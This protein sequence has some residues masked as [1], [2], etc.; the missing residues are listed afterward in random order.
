MGMIDPL[1]DPRYQGE[2]FKQWKGLQCRKDPIRTAQ[3]D[4][5]REARAN[6]IKNAEQRK[7]DIQELREMRIMLAGRLKQV[8]RCTCR[9]THNVQPSSNFF[10]TSFATLRPS[11]NDRNRLFGMNL[12][13]SD[14]LAARKALMRLA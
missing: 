2:I 5:R 7:V 9:L 13:R 11:L 14:Y 1:T 4:H 10:L 6:G 8:M 12:Q 3:E